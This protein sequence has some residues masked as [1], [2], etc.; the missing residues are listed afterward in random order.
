MKNVWEL[1]SKKQLMLVAPTPDEK[2]GWFR[3]M[4]NLKKKIQKQQATGDKGK[5]DLSILS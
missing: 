1:Q 3:E 2:N 5:V 4:K